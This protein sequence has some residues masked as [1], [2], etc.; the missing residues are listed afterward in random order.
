MIY[1]ST[2]TLNELFSYD[3]IT[4]KLY[5]KPRENSMFTSDRSAKIWNTKYANKEAGTVASVKN[6]DTLK[7]IHVSIFNKLY[8]A[9]VLI[10]LM[11]HGNINGVID[12][13]DGNGLNN[14]MDNLR[15]IPQSTNVRKCKMRKNNTTGYRGVTVTASGKFSVSITKNRKKINLGIFED[16][17]YASKI[18]STAALILEGEVFSETI[19]F[20]QNS[21]EYESV[22]NKLGISP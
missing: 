2:E 19:P 14:K 1:P 13:I 4:G 17:I 12:H 3:S 15:D 6:S 16:I 18:Y 11:I 7:Y 20:K 5:W 9:H 10:W 8:R 22:K 21:P